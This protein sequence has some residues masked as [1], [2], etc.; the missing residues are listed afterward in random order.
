MPSE[1]NIERERSELKLFGNY[2]DSLELYK[3]YN[4]TLSK[5]HGLVKIAIQQWFP[6]P[7]VAET[8]TQVL[9]KHPINGF[10]YFL[11]MHKTTIKY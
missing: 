3:V 9:I 2:E 1:V 10:V 11:R 4:A 5:R 7:D 6:R 8:Y